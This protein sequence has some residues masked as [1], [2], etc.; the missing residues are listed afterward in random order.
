M[1][2]NW[3]KF[4]KIVLGIATLGLSLLASGKVGSGRKT[5]KVGEVG[6]EIVDEISKA[7]EDKKEPG[8]P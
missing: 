1:K 3:S 8:T 7:T 6:G 5:K 4:G 2:I